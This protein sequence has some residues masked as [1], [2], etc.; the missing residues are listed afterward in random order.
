M[1]AWRML[2]KD[3]GFAESLFTQAKHFLASARQSA[4][5][6]AQEGL[7]RASIVFSLMSFEA[8]FFEVVNGYI[9]QK[10]ATLDPT[11]RMKVQDGLVKH[12]GIHEALRDWPKFLTGNSLDTTTKAY[13]DFVN[14]TKYRNALLHGKITENIPSWGKLAQDVETIDGAELAQR[15][16]SEMVK[17]VARH[18]GFPIRTW[19]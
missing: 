11:G 2:W 13:A 4:S 15:T 8:Y 5:G 14:F 7:I 3:W 19:V 18:F 12:T 1:R 6:S 10:G 16:V 9:Q 17:A